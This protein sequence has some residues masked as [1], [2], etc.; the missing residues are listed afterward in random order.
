MIQIHANLRGLAGRAK[1]PSPLQKRLDYVC[2]QF[3]DDPETCGYVATILGEVVGDLHEDPKEAEHPNREFC[4][5]TLSEAPATY[6]FYRFRKIPISV[7]EWRDRQIKCFTRLVDAT[8]STNALAK[9]TPWVGSLVRRE[10]VAHR[11]GAGPH[12]A[13]RSSKPSYLCRLNWELPRIVAWHALA[14]PDLTRMDL[15]TAARAAAHWLTA[16]RRRDTVTS[17]AF[18]GTRLKTWSDKW[19]LY[20]LRTAKEIE[21]EGRAMGHCLADDPEAHCTEITSHRGRIMSLRDPNGRPR[22]TLETGEGKLTEFKGRFNNTTLDRTACRR[23]VRAATFMRVKP[24]ESL[25]ECSR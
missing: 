11:R 22:Y 14:K 19:S 17:K 7:V 15:D 9:I 23:L 13:H 5:G 24:P 12:P 18:P 8:P 16:Y 20:D 4:P 2:A 21:A 25:V 6:R 1:G 3:Q 10:L